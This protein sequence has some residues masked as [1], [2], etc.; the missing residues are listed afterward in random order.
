MI[1]A[2]AY[3]VV[4]FDTEGRE[5]IESAAATIRDVINAF[6][7][8]GGGTSSVE[9]NLEEAMAVLYSIIDGERW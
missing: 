8:V 1:T 2:N 3:T 9:E 6:R 5:R 7:K 4:E